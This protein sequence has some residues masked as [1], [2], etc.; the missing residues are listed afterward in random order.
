MASK[1]TQQDQ[2]QTT[3]TTS[4]GTGSSSSDADVLAQLEAAASGTTGPYALPE[5]F[6]FPARQL[7][8]GAQYQSNPQMIK[9]LVR[10]GIDANGWSYV[11]PRLVDADGNIVRDQYD[12]TTEAYQELASMSQADRRDFLK[13]LHQRGLYD[14]GEPSSYGFSS[15]DIS[16]TGKA[17]LYANSV[18]R[19]LDSAVIQLAQDFPAV[20]SGGTSFRRAAAD[21]LRS[22]VVQ[23]FH[24][25]LGRKPS[26]KDIDNFISAYRSAETGEM[27]GAAGSGAYDQAASA[28]TIAEKQ[29]QKTYQPEQD[30][31]GFVQMAQMFERMLRGA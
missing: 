6:K 14:S 11:G 21:D 1:K 10:T 28:Q 26:K 20:K 18:G 25:Q 16:A 13:T 9:Y 5:N 30:A 3:T 27:A 31:Y 22:V 23:V 7:K 2:Q 8:A 29:V 12:A 15:S 19:T 17:M 4:Q 24:Q